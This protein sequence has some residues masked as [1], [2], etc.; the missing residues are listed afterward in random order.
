M[1]VSLNFSEINLDYKDKEIYN[2]VY[3]DK[4]SSHYYAVIRE[5][6]YSSGLESLSDNFRASIE[7]Q[8]CKSLKS[9]D[10]KV[11][12]GQP[13]YA[14]SFVDLKT[15]KKWLNDIVNTVFELH[16]KEGF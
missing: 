16:I 1:K 12:V 6:K 5:S 8:I 2:K 7:Y 4:L 14:R 10:P 9:F 15:S 3:V 13:L 11:S